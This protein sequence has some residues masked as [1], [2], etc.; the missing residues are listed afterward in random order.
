M[1][2]DADPAHEEWT[3]LAAAHQPSS[4]AAGMTTR[5]LCGPGGI[6]L[7]SNEGVM[8]ATERSTTFE[9]AAGLFPLGAIGA[10]SNSLTLGAYLARDSLV[11]INAEGHVSTRSLPRRTPTDD[12]PRGISVEVF[13]DGVVVFESTPDTYSLALTGNARR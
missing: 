10:F 11:V 4:V 3:D 6:V 13:R 2:H 1:H 5:M 12:P 8:L 7:M 9:P